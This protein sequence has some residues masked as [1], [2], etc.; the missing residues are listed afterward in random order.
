MSRS[1]HVAFSQLIRRYHPVSS[2]FRKKITLIWL[3]VP[4]EDIYL[5]LIPR[6]LG[7]ST[8]DG[9]WHVIGGIACVKNSRYEM[10]SPLTPSR[11]TT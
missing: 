1:R 3:N 7:M 10:P 6:A 2:Y 11:Q 4:K 9:Q 8:A 5:A